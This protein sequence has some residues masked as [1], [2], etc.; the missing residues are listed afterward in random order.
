MALSSK[1]KYTDRLEHWT[2]RVEHY[3]DVCGDAFNTVTLTDFSERNKQTHAEPTSP[4]VPP[5]PDPQHTPRMWEDEIEG[6]VE[7]T[8]R[9]KSPDVKKK[10]IKFRVA[11]NQWLDNDPSRRSYGDEGTNRQ[12]LES[13]A[14]RKV[15]DSTQPP[16]SGT[17]QSSSGVKRSAEPDLEIEDEEPSTK[18]HAVGAWGSTEDFIE[19]L[20]KLNEKETRVS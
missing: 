16:D 14:Q 10:M 18:V 2:S 3:F 7:A 9:S 12:G 13:K 15:P 1:P 19:M 8:T 4:A 20:K 5:S 6:P 11:K 17:A